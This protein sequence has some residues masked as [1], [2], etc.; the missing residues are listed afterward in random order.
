MVK[1]DL[2]YLKNDLGVA[3]L[4]LCG[5]VTLAILLVVIGYILIRGL[6]AITPEFLLESPRKFMREGGIFPSIVTTIYITVI[7]VL[8][9]TPVSVGAAIYLAEYAGENRLTKLVRFGADSLAGI[10]SI[11]FGMFGYL[12]FVY[13]MGMGTSLIAG[14]L[15]LALMAFPII[16]RIS[17]EAVKVI[18]RSY[19]EGSLALGSTKWQ[20]IRRIVLPAAF[21]GIVTGIILGIGRAAGETAAVLLTAG[22][23]ARVPESLSDPVSTMTVQIYILAMENLSMK[24]AFGTAALLVLMILAITLI[25]NFMTRR[26][27]KKLGGRA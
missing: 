16:M 10:P 23:V 4:W 20:M 5:A 25:S 27:L 3:L 24:N 26:Y 11:M 12:F 9:A 18:P 15:T 1:R 6:G 19:K 7:A 21:P 17:E 8:V 14:G 13:W 2:R 22:S